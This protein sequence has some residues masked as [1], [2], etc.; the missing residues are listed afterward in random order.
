M[1]MV[2]DMGL[3][4][5]EARV[6]ITYNGRN[7]DL[8]EP[9]PFDASDRQIKEWVREAV[10]GG[11][12]PGVAVRGRVDLSHFVVDRFRSNGTTPYNRIFLRPS[13]PFG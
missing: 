13:T 9:V 3:M 7:G 2:N 6:N 1:K 5:H 4:A 8:A 12:I 11:S 10:T